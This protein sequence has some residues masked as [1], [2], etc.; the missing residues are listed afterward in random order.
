MKIDQKSIYLIN[1][2][3]RIRDMIVLSDEFRLRINTFK[4]VVLMKIYI[5]GMEDGPSSHFFLYKFRKF[6][7]SSHVPVS[8]NVYLEICQNRH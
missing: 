5:N 8:S 4:L 3:M 6:I 2:S 1:I 7:H